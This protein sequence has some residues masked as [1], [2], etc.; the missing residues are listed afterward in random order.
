M[1]PL[2]T[3]FLILAALTGAASAQ[4]ALTSAANAQDA[5]PLRLCADPANLPFSTSAQN[6]PA[7]GLHIEIGQAVAKALG[8]PLETVWSLSNFGK[9]NLRDTMLAGRCDFAVGLPATD[10]FMGPAVIFSKPILT[11]GYAMVTTGAPPA[12]LAD[13]DGKRVAVQFGSPPQSLV[14]TR[15]AITAVT[16]MDPEAAMRLLGEGRVDAAFVWGPSAGYDN[17]AR[18]QNAYT[19]RPVDGPQ[20]RYQAAIGF[21]RKNPALRDS[22]DAILPALA[23]QIAALTQKYGLPDGAP[24]TLAAAEAPSEPVQTAN[25]G[26]GRELFNGTCAHCHG[27][28]AVQAERRINLRLLQHRHGD[29]AHDTFLTAVHNGRPSKGMPA[30]AGV[31]TDDDFAS[32][33]AYLQTVQ[34]P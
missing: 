4:S 9:R 10:D 16:V 13:L 2:P 18:R 26:R 30:W 33:Y 11:L 17:Q 8:R 27:P 7:P 15:D 25:A 32:I 20:M 19:V 12:R 22:V 31:F 24:I 34:E 6:E 3:A 5:S 1:R 23:P 21:S 29:D 28:D 14:A